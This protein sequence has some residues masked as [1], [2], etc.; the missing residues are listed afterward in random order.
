MAQPTWEVFETPIEMS[1]EWFRGLSMHGDTG[2]LVGGAGLVYRTDGAAA[3]LL[4]AETETKRI[5]E[6]GG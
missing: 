4:G 1:S 6:H 5:I 3:T 2:Y